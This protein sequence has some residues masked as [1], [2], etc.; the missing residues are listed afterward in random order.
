[1]RTVSAS[2]ED[3]LAYEAEQFCKDAGTTTSNLIRSLLK[4]KV[5]GAVSLTSIYSSIEARSKEATRQFQDL[6]KMLLLTM[7]EEVITQNFLLMFVT[8]YIRDKNKGGTMPRESW[9]ALELLEKKMKENMKEID[10][11]DKLME[12]FAVQEDSPK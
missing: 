10:E 7:E 9:T 12:K 1:M 2:V 11:A 6:A 3:E 8:G 4:E 5:S